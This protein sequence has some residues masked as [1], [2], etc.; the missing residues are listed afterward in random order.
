MKTSRI[1]AQ[2]LRRVIILSEGASPRMPRPRTLE[3]SLPLARNQNFIAGSLWLRGSTSTLSKLIPS[4]HLPSR[5][6]APAIAPA[7]SHKFRRN[8]RWTESRPHPRCASR[9][10]LPRRWRS[11]LPAAEPC[12]HSSESPPPEPATPIA[13]FPTPPRSETLPRPQLHLR[14]PG[15]APDPSAAPAAAAYST[16]APESPTTARPDSA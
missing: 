12:A 14:E 13:R 6:S 3:E 5:P 10:Q 4:P 8:R 1:Q 2:H 16:A 7:A 11:H 9:V 15:C